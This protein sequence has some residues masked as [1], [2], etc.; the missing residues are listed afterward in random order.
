MPK[1]KI[2][3]RICPNC[4]KVETGKSRD[5]VT[6]Y[7]SY[8]CWRVHCA[9]KHLKTG[10]YGRCDECEE[11]FYI[12]GYRLGQGSGHYCSLNCYFAA[13]R[14]PEKSCPVCKKRFRKHTTTCSQ[15]CSKI[16]VLNP[17]WKGG[18]TKRSRTAAVRQWRLAVFQRDNFTC[19]GCGIQDVE[20][21]AHH[22]KNFNRYPELRLDVANGQTLCAPCHR[23]TPDYGGNSKPKKRRIDAAKEAAKTQNN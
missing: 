21:H 4:G 19:Q 20:L 3:T 15:R 5:L 13:K 16:G 10:A 7:C 9:G 2:K 23:L 18:I 1:L 12:R 14:V 6:L 8:E 22:I 17:L 11:V